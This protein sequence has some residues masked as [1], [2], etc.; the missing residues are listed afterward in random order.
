MVSYIGQD[1]PFV[2]DDTVRAAG[3]ALGLLR[4]AAHQGFRLVLMG[5]CNRT[6]DPPTRMYCGVLLRMLECSLSLELLIAKGRHRDAATLLVTMI[7]LRLDLQFA[8]RDPLRV[9]EWL[10]HT[11]RGR[12][13]WGAP[14]QIKKLF[15][16][17]QERAAE[18]ENYRNLCM[19]K[20]G[21]PGSGPAGFPLSFDGEGLSVYDDQVGR[22]LSVIYLFGAGANLNAGFS[23][24]TQ[25]FD[26]SEMNLDP[27]LELIEARMRRLA[28]IHARHAYAMMQ[29][30]DKVS[31]GGSPSP[32]EM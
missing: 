26:V 22:N 11:D 23:T 31:V 4:A 29:T 24:I 17:D 7:E 3:A 5:C 6:V 21:N 30:I 9:R 13:P 25:L 14:A 28:D 32:D 12:K 10:N 15:L 19:I 16:G 20:H 27:V 2:D 1:P 18:L 8:A